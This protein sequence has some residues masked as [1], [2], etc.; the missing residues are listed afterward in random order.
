MHSQYDSSVYDSPQEQYF[1]FL[2]DR[3]EE[4]LG[5]GRGDQV[6]KH[7]SEAQKMQQ[8][9]NFVLN[10]ISVLDIFLQEIIWQ[11]N[12]QAILLRQCAN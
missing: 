1:Y 7:L 2:L 3:I 10:G 6:Q 5:L 4:G 12:E 9:Y 8:E 11:N